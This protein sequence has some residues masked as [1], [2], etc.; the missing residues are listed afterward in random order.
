MQSLLHALD[1]SLLEN[2]SE[3]HLANVARWLLATLLLGSRSAFAVGPE[4]QSNDPIGEPSSIQPIVIQFDS[5]ALEVAAI[6]FRLTHDPAR[7]AFVQI[8]T[9][10]PGSSSCGS[11][12]NRFSCVVQAPMGGILPLTGTITIRTQIL[13]AASPGN[14][15]LTFSD[16]A[17]S[18]LVG[19]K[20]DP[21]PVRNGV[22]TVV[23]A[24]GP[25][26]SFQPATGT[27][28]LLGGGDGLVGSTAAAEISLTANSGT[29]SSSTTFNQCAIVPSTGFTSVSNINLTLGTGTAMQ[30]VPVSCVRGTVEA[31]ATLTCRETR[32]GQAP[33]NRSWPLSCPGPERIFANNFEP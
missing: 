3:S 25:S 2:Y 20:F 10:M 17:F 13:A 12:M 6:T 24:L 32:A 30:A 21:G 1:C 14:F 27:R 26:L 28:I 11:F 18:D 8:Q 15:P 9:S 33:S 7:I 19:N 23:P 4:L 29:G 22:F 31:A 5:D 16:L